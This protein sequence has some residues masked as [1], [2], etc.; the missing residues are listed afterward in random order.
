MDFSIFSTKVC[1]KEIAALSE[2]RLADIGETKKVG[3]GYTF[4]LSK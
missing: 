3:A 1:E 4:F 2:T